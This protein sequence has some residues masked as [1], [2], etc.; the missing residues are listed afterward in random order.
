MFTLPLFA[1]LQR[2]AELTPFFHSILSSSRNLFILVDFNCHHPSETQEVL[3]TLV[4]RKYSTGWSL[5]TSS[6]SM[7]LTYLPFYI[8]P[9]VVA[10]LLTFLLLP[11]IFFSSYF[12]PPFLARARCFRTWV[13]ITYQFFYLSLSLQSFIPTNIPPPIFRKL[14]GMTLTLTVLLQKN[15]WL[16]FSLLLLSSLLWHWMRPNLPFFSAASNTILK[17]GGPLKWKKGLVKDAKLSLPLTEVMKIARLT[18]LLPDALCLSSPRLRHGRPLA[19]LFCPNL[20]LNLYTLIFALLLAL[21]P[22]L[23]TP[24][25]VHLS[26]SGL[27][28]LPPTWDPTFPFLSQR[29]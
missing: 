9:L 21:F 16:F 17:P 15:T 25:T 23:L 20:T 6:S 14:A 8:A 13:L 1:L 3:P 10:L 12:A 11:P 22:P 28:S 7:T 5:M 18:S 26:G 24:P 27:R 2:M 29:P 19:L 4:E